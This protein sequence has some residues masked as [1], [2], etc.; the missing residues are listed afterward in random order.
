FHLPDLPTS[1][2]CIGQPL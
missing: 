2:S 1:R